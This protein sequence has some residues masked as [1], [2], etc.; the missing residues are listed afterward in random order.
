[1]RGRHGYVRCQGDT[2]TDVLEMIQ[3]DAGTNTE[4]VVITRNSSAVLTRMMPIR[5]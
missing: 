4:N 5:Y 3:E 1:M 2:D